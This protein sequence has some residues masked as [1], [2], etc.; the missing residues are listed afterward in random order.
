[1]AAA[2]KTYFQS[3]E[4]VGVVV[5][6]GTRFELLAKNPL[7]E[8]TLASYAVADGALFIRS[9]ETLYRIKEAGK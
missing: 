3:E 2:G 1:V 9:A 4:G 5:T 6:A 8:R 7:N